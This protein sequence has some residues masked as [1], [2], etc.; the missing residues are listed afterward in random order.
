MKGDFT[1][2]TFRPEKH[3]RSVLMQ[4]G[5]VQTDA[6]WNEELDIEAHLDETTRLDVIGPCGAPKED[7]GFQ[8][9]ALP[10]AADLA[11]SAGRL[12]VDG[13][14][15]ELEASTVP[16][17]I[18]AGGQLRVQD[19]VVDAR[20]LEPPQWIAVFDAA[21]AAPSVHVAR[22]TSVD[23]TNRTVQFSPPLSTAA[24]AALAAAGAGPSVRRVPTYATQTDLP[25]PP[26]T[27][28]GTAASPSVVELSDGTYL[29]YADVWTRHITALDDPDIREPALGGPDTATRVK[30]VCQVR[31]TRL[32]GP[33]ASCDG[34]A[35]W[36]ALFADGETNRRPST[37]RLRAR[38]RQAAPSSTPCVI[39]PSAGYRRLENQ[40]YRVE[41]HQPGPLGTA[42]FKWSRENGSIVTRWI[43]QT[44]N[45]LTVSSTGRDSVLGFASGHLVELVDDSRE[46]QGQPGTLVDLVAP[47]AGAVLTINPAVPVDRADFPGNPKVRRW[48]CPVE[49]SVAR[50]A[51]ND[52]FLALEEGVEVRFENGHYNTGDY[53]LIPARTAT[54]DVEWPRDAQGRPLPQPPD[55]IAHHYCRLA[56][57][58][59][60]AGAV[61]VESCTETFPSLTAMCAEDVCFDNEHCQIP[62]AATV[63]DALDAMCEEGNL[64][65]HKKHLH[66]WGIVCGLQLK[67]GPDSEGPRRHITVRS[68]YAIECEGN[69]IIVEQD[70]ALDVLAMTHALE[71]ED[72]NRPVLHE[73]DGEVCLTLALDADR[74]HRF[75]VERYEPRTNS[76]ASVL[77]GTLLMDV[78]RDCVE[79]VVRFLRSQLTAP[80]GQG[81][82]AGS[83]TASVL[84]N[85]LAQIADPKSGQSIFL[86]QREDAILRTFYGRLRSLLSS[87]TFCAMF[88]NARPFPDYP[89][90]LAQMDTIF[91]R[92][93]HVRVRLRPSSGA[94][95][96]AYTVG[97]GVNPLDPSTLINRYDLERGELVDQIDPVAGASTTGRA[98][99]SG[100]GG[101]SDVAFSPDGNRIFMVAPTRDGKNTLFRAGDIAAAGVSWGPLVTLCDVRLVTLATTVAEPQSVFAVGRGTGIYRINPDSPDPDMPVLTEFVAAGHLRITP[102]GLAVATANMDESEPTSYAAVQFVNLATGATTRIQL[103]Q[104]GED[105]IAVVSGQGTDVTAYCVVGRSGSDEKAVVAVTPN[106]PL[107]GVTIPVNDTAV[108]LET[109][110]NTTIL[111]TSE[112]ANS[113]TMIDVATNKAVPGY[114]LPLQA[115]PVAVAVNPRGDAYALN[116]V[117]NTITAVPPGVLTP[118]FRYPF[119]ALAAYRKG[120]LEANADLLAGFLQYLKDC[121]CDHFLVDCPTCTGEETLYLGCISFRKGQVERVCNFSQRRYVKSFPTMEY[122]LSA[123]PI[124]PLA[125]R[126]IEQLCCAALPD[127]FSK[128]SAKAFDEGSVGRTGPSRVG[129]VREGLALAQSF[130]VRSRWREV[131]SRARLAMK[132]S[133][134]SVLRRMASGPL[135]STQRMGGLVDRPVD[136]AQAILKQA[137]ANVVTKPVEDLGIGDVLRALA[138]V[139]A[140]E[141]GARHDVTLHEEK[142]QVRF[143]SASPHAASA[144][145][146]AQI[147]ALTEALAARDSDLEELRARLAQV[148]SASQGGPPGSD[149]S[150]P[151]GDT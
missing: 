130:D 112:A 52:G 150:A 95:A 10:G 108:R 149:Q 58:R 54:G 88:D 111:V 101:V 66:G 36:P 136:A 81:A 16:A 19:L 125:Q 92:G 26:F 7:A 5:R 91:G 20:Q 46:L 15:C 72:P 90:E 57:V 117:T 121:V 32:P 39:P 44:A 141:P 33:V 40:L 87:Q 118:N 70:E 12:Y 124:A 98:T 14:L 134:S 24:Q 107:G 71:A 113:L 145:V 49:A 67:C 104:S 37:G 106:G 9:S 74:G 27:T 102:G 22:V 31:L 1:R 61:S 8:L 69:D 139:F 23:T 86:S 62:G 132:L 83:E 97:P 45:R 122:W 123:V 77:A 48:D 105:D 28:T 109:H 126:L 25:R 79:P 56:L 65:R 55:G 64:R 41:V 135:R 147:D 143:A 43:S 100:S 85:L 84:A 3:Y 29:A 114:V 116:Y 11:I 120:V 13:L 94:G 133:R 75:A 89:A 6:D 115:G 42:K 137:G 30:T 63:Q 80:S 21:S 18:V 110:Q 73:G 127:I 131:R 76:T 60:A 119:A 53:W 2:S 140:P 17:T 142:G 146:Q 82:G 34:V 68:G 103:P 128:F 129:T 51:A 93:R 35:D 148:E 151:D 38:A 138:G 47:P 99:A 78:Y 59:V 144:R 50:P 96:E 4:Q